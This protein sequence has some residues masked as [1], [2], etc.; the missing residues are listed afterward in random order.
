MAAPYCLIYKGAMYRIPR[1]AY[2]TD[3]H[4]A[5]RAWRMMPLLA[6][7]VPPTQSQVR[8]A[9]CRA[10]MTILPRRMGVTYD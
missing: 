3:E 2:E 8:A 9:T 1:L 7:S 6:T 4:V 5:E 10:L